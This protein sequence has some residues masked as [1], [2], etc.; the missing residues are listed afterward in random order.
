MAVALTT[1]E[2]PRLWNL[3]CERELLLEVVPLYLFKPKFERLFEFLESVRPSARAVLSI[4]RI[5]PKFE[6]CQAN[7]I[8]SNQVK[9]FY[10][11]STLSPI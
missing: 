11:P 5:D 7:L 10:W 9:F 1:S 4:R 8:K 2:V 6:R 3:L